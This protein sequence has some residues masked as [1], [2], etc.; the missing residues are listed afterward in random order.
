MTPISE[1]TPA[2]KRGRRYWFNLLRFGLIVFLVLIALVTYVVMPALQ[3][4]AWAHPSRT[5]LGDFTPADM[6]LEYEAVTFTTRDGLTLAGW[7][8][9]SQNGA[10]ITIAHG[11][12]NNRIA[13]MH[14]A[15][16]LVQHG[17]GVLVFDLRGHGE[18]AGEIT[19]L[20]GEDVL[21]ALAYVQG[22]ADVDPERV[23]AMGLSLGAMV[24]LEAAAQTGAIKAVVAD[25]VSIGMLQDL[26]PPLAFEDWVML[27]GGLTF[28]GVRAIYGVSAPMSIGE[29]VTKVSPRPIL[30][31]SGAANDLERRRVRHFY[32]LAGEPKTLWEIPEAGHGG[33]RAARPDEYAERLIDFFDAALL[34]DAQG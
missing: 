8:M 14:E 21:A 9:P 22:R 15:W 12:G 27:P 32:E 26:F 29:A 10:A 4:Y 7:Y 11:M 23:G 33:T 30:F 28:F 2:R 3:A 13:H 25:G 18:S 31:I 19:G 5:P 20:G 24:T 34:S 6:E 16:T 1:Q 17:Y